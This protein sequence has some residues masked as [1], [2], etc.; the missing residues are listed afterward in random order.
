MTHET[1]HRWREKRSNRISKK[2]QQERPNNQRL[3]NGETIDST[4]DPNQQPTQLLENPSNPLT[5]DSTIDRS[6]S[7]YEKSGSKL[8]KTALVS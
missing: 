2:K 8:D 1:A 5:I 3:I 6:H 7:H 4:V